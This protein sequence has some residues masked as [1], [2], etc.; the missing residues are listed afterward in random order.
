MICRLCLEDADEGKWA[1]GEVEA[2][3]LSVSTESRPVIRTVWH[4]YAL[5]LISVHTEIHKST[6]MIIDTK[7]RGMHKQTF[8]HFGRA[9]VSTSASS[10]GLMYWSQGSIA[11][12]P[13]AINSLGLL[14]GQ[15]VYRSLQTMTVSH[16]KDTRYSVYTI[17]TW[18]NIHH[19]YKCTLVN[20]FQRWSPSWNPLGKS[21][22][23]VNAGSPIAISLTFLF[24]SG[25][26]VITLVILWLLAP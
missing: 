14:D 16:P 17:L 26:T 20:A 19:T 22:P 12:L 24:P 15:T 4:R 2:F 23:G 25:W 18:A 11:A 8:T 9:S 13:A 5:I 21:E 1:L 3:D 10:V 6:N 7:H